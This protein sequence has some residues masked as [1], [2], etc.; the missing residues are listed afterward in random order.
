[1]DKQAKQS[2]LSGLNDLEKEFNLNLAR[3]YNKGAHKSGVQVTQNL[4]DENCEHPREVIG[5]ICGIFLKALCNKN[6]V[7]VAK[8]S[9]AG[10]FQFLQFHATL[11]GYLAFRF[12]RNMI[13][14][15]KDA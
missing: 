8:S 1:M 11:F 13:D 4:I 14:G 6:L 2:A 9:S 10:S 5:K 7:Q 3:I 12:Q 15:V